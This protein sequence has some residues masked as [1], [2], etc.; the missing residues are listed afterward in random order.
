MPETN[1]NQLQSEKKN[2]QK[3]LEAFSQDA[4]N[5]EE[6]IKSEKQEQLQKSFSDLEQKVTDQLQKENNEEIKK[7]QQEIADL[8]LQYKELLS[9][10]KQEASSL[11]AG[12]ENARFGT[13]PLE[14]LSLLEN[15]P[16]K[17]RMLKVFADESFNAYPELKDKEAEERIEIVF[18]KINTVLTRFYARKFNISPAEPLPDYLAQVIVPA[19][20]RF[21]MDMLKET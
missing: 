3:Q 11:Q 2:L 17:T 15:T 20:E 14:T 21:L 19:T 18:R 10:T 4:Q 13:A 8:K 9:Q 7:L 12:V 6:T 5:L 16:L 1:I